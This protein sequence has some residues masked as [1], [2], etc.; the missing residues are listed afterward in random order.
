MSC[1]TARHSPRPRRS[2][3]SSPP[4]ALL[5]WRRSSGPSTRRRACGR[6]RP[7]PTNRRT[8]RPCSTPTTPRK[9]PRPSQRSG[10]RTSS[11]GDGAVTRSFVPSDEVARIRGRIDH[12]VIDSDGHL[13]EFLPLVR[14]FLVE[15]AGPALA[16]NLDPVIG[17]PP[18]MDDVPRET[19]RAMGLSRSPWWG[20]PAANTLD[21]ATAMFPELFV[22]RM[23]E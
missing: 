8:G 23:E 12:P 1:P 20:L 18:P 7:S 10:F 21:R 14:D 6:T 4:T 3:P 11:G 19:R 17:G 9:G 15:E 5:P 2:P 16:G 13:L 22:Q